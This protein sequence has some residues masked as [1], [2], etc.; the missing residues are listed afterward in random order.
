MIVLTPH[1]QAK[2]SVLSGYPLPL[3]EGLFLL[4]LLLLAI[5]GA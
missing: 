3:G 4:A 5:A 2:Q 1:P